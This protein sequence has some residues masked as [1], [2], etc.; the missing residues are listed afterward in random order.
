MGYSFRLAARVLLYAPSHRQDS[1]YH[2]LCHWL[3]RKIAQWVHPMK[4]R[5]D[6]PSHHERTLLPRSYI[7]LRF[8]GCDC[9]YQDF[10]LCNLVALCSIV[11]KKKL[12]QWFYIFKNS[13]MGKIT[14]IKKCELQ[15]SHDWPEFCLVARPKEISWIHHYLISI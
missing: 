1:T 3:E 6:D 15:S 12:H 10:K 4:D 5:S 8:G 14:G 7:S 13:K 11:L 9:S 2:G